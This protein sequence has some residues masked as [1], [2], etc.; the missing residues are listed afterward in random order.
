MEKK[1]E[2][3]HRTAIGAQYKPTCKLK[4][5]RYS[6]EIRSFRNQINIKTQHVKAVQT[7]T[8]QT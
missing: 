1:E 7:R 3:Q 4:I 5:T 8:V 6:R 2:K